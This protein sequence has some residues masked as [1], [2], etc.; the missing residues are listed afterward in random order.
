MKIQVNKAKDKP[1]KMIWWSRENIFL[2]PKYL[3]D[4]KTADESSI[5]FLHNISD[6]ST[7]P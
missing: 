2:P 1:F 6:V 4:L 7:N 5:S 3:Q